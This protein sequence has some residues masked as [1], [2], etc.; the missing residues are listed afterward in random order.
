MPAN[1]DTADDIKTR[2]QNNMKRRIKDMAVLK[3][4]I[5]Q[6]VRHS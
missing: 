2:I 3:D 6:I 5:Q 1:K 4:A